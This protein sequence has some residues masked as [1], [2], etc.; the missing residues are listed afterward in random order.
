MDWP[1]I[2]PRLP[3]R[4]AAELPP[5]PRHSPQHRESIR[6]LMSAYQF[7]YIF[8]YKKIIQYFKFV[9]YINKM[10]YKNPYAWL[11]QFWHSTAFTISVPLNARTRPS[12]RQSTCGYDQRDIHCTWPCNE[13]NSH[14]QSQ[15]FMKRSIQYVFNSTHHY[16][17]TSPQ[18]QFSQMMMIIIIY[19]TANELSPS[20]S[21]YRSMQ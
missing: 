20:G 11:S 18:A 4:E 9:L 12:K 2:E 15:I 10:S 7:S 1:G 6:S 5:Q 3:W 19:L 14:T 17:S 13:D 21:G 16:K 8:Q